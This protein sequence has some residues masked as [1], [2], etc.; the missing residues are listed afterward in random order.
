[1]Y[2]YRSSLFPDC[3][4]HPQRLYGFGDVMRPDDPRPV[5]GRQQMSGDRAA[6]TLMRLRGRHRADEA[7]ARGT[8]QQWQSERLQLSEP[9]QCG[10]ALLGRLA[11]A[12]TGIEDNFVRRNSGAGSNVERSCKEIGDVLHD[13]DSRIGT[14]AVMHDD[15]GRAALGDE[16][17]HAGIA[18]QAPDIVGD[19]GTLMERP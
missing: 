7:F 8:D 17:S 11:E 1:S 15:D 16:A 19:G 4:G 6:E 10:H 14:L 3:R 9:R 2:R 12:D 13:V 18:L 5:L